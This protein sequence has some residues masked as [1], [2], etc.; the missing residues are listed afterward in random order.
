MSEQGLVILLNGTSSAGKSSIALALQDAHPDPILYLGWDILAHLLSPQFLTADPKAN[1]AHWLRHVRGVYRAVGAHASPGNWVIFDTVL[2]RDEDLSELQEALAGQRVCYVGVH[3]PLEEAE[4]REMS[5]GD[6]VPG[7]ARMQFDVVHRRGAYDVEVNT[8]E[9]SP[10]DAAR[11]I[12]DFL[13]HTPDPTAFRS[14]A[15][16]PVTP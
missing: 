10:E 1:Q 9:L 16:T 6:R 5:R 8:A 15:A 7:T 3:C 12:L 14:A 13:A 2:Q 4:R 11:R